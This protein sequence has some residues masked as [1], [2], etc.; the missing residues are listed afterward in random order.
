MG[1]AVAIG[2]VLAKATER[3][4]D[5]AWI[6][7]TQGCIIG[8]ESLHH[9]WSKTFD[10]HIGSRRQLVQD[11]LPLGGLQV[12]AEAALV[13][14][15]IAKRRLALRACRHSRARLRAESRW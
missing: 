14:V 11:T 6:E 12:Q 15:H 5:Q 10:Q 3:A 9:A 13:A 8:V 4:V 7:A 2:A 1:R